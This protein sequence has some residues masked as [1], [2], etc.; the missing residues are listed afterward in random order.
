MHRLGTNIHQGRHHHKESDPST[1][2]RQQGILPSGT[3]YGVESEQISGP[4]SG[5]SGMS[6]CKATKFPQELLKIRVLHG[7]DV[8]SVW[9]CEPPPPPLPALR[10]HLVTKG[11]WLWATHRVMPKAPEN[12]VLFAG[13]PENAGLGSISAHLRVPEKAG[14]R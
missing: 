10:A 12:F 14:V 13:T 8:S 7:G 1:R 6:D 11:Q 3:W 5:P 9:V 4:V 2:V